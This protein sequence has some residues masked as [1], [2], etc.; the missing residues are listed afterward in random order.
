MPIGPKGE[1]GPSDVIA[2]A[3]HVMRIATGEAKEE[4]VEPG[5]ERRWQTRRTRSR[6]NHEPI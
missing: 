4:Y 6:Q 5:Q 1:K 3:V 2:N